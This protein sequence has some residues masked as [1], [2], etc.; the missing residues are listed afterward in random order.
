MDKETYVT[1]HQAADKLALAAAHNSGF[2]N[3]ADC[4]IKNYEK[5]LEHLISEY[6]KHDPKH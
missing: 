3:E 4:Y 2:N 5:V 1:L 6:E